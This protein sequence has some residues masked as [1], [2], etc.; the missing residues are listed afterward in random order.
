VD[1]GEVLAEFWIWFEALA[2]VLTSRQREV[3][4]LRYQRDLDDET[5]GLV[6]HLSASGVRSLT[7]R[8]LERIRAHPEL[9]R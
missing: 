4:V 6:M 3:L 1:E 2:S 9:M 5:I 8:A 7:S